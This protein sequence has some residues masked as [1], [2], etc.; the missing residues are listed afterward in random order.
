MRALTRTRRA[1]HE[2]AGGSTTARRMAPAPKSH[3]G[4]WATRPLG[5]TSSCGPGCAVSCRARLRRHR[6]PSLSHPPRSL[7][8]MIEALESRADLVLGFT[9]TRRAAAD[10][11]SPLPTAPASR[12]G[13]VPRSQGA[14]PQVYWVP[15]RLRALATQRRTGRDQRARARS[16]YVLQDGNE[17]S[18][19]ARVELPFPRSATARSLPVHLMTWSMPII[20]GPLLTLRHAWPVLRAPPAGRRSRR[21][22]NDSARPRGGAAGS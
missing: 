7:P 21:L 5:C 18:A 13:W 12:A 17:H 8:Q 2:H 16:G 9:G 19:R 3:A 14:C 10:G 22:Q 20:Y 4:G 11:G 6:R 15:G 1:R